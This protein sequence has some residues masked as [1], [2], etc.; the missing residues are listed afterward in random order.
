MRPFIKFALTTALLSFL[1]IW[2]YWFLWAVG[3]VVLL[4]FSL[5]MMGG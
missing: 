3:R 2:I 4:L 5:M 1:L